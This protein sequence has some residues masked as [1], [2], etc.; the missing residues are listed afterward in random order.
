MVLLNLKTLI[1]VLY[2]YIYLLHV[3]TKLN[4]ILPNHV[5]HVLV[6]AMVFQINSIA[7]LLIFHFNTVI[8]S[9]MVIPPISYYNIGCYQIKEALIIFG[10]EHF[11][12]AFKIYDIHW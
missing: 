4:D 6:E 11:Y 5:W 1:F 9:L 12:I 3:G 2:R 10:I 8:I 7:I